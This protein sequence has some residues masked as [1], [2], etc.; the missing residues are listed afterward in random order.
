LVVASSDDGDEADEL[1]D[2]DGDTSSD[3]G[4]SSDDGEIRT[5]SGD[6]QHRQRWGDSSSDEEAVT[7]SPPPYFSTKIT[8]QEGA[9]W[10]N[11]FNMKIWQQ[12]GTISRFEELAISRVVD[13]AE[14][15]SGGDVARISPFG[16]DVVKDP[17]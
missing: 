9:G 15:S 3:E 11:P 4:T 7:A 13:E 1:Y 2:S 16:P 10:L 5:A 6:S 17:G 12:D 14:S 8:L